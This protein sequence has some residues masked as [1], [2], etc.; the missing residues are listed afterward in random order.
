[1]DTIT[2]NQAR[3]ALWPDPE[4]AVAGPAREHYQIFGWCHQFFARQRHLGRRLAAVHSVDAPARLRA[5]LGLRLTEAGRPQRRRLWTVAAVAAAVLI[6]GLVLRPADPAAAFAPAASHLAGM[7]M[8]GDTTDRQT[9]SAWLSERL[10]GPLALPDIPGAA[11]MGAELLNVHG[12]TWAGARYRLQGMT[13]AYFARP[14]VGMEP[15]STMRFGQSGGWVV[16]IWT[17]RGGMRALAGGPP[18]TRDEILAL[19]SDCRA[20]AAGQPPSSS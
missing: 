8:N 20:R 19:A 16:A 9:A 1:M 13:L 15:D 11:F 18:L 2:C 12:S 3:E 4:T 5:R 10:A 6:T 17:E 14:V 7:P